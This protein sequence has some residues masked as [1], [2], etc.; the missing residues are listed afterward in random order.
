MFSQERSVS[1]MLPPPLKRTSM[2]TAFLPSAYSYSSRSKRI[3]FGPPMPA[4]WT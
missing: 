2:M 4:M 3:W 1:A